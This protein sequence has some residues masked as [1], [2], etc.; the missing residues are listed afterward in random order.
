MNYKG[1]VLFSIFTFTPMGNTMQ[2]TFNSYDQKQVITDPQPEFDVCIICAE[3]GSASIYRALYHHYLNRHSLDSKL[4]Y[5][6]NFCNYAHD[7]KNIKKH[8]LKVHGVKI[9]LGQL[10]SIRIPCLPTRVITE[11]KIQNYSNRLYALLADAE[12]QANSSRTNCSTIIPQSELLTS[13]P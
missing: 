11:E 5:L 6:C 10:E 8:L 4:I 1:W 9:V 3:N 7:T 2:F 12:F 13:Y